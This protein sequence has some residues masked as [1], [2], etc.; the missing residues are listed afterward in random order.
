MV[1]YFEVLYKQMLLPCRTK[2]KTCLIRKKLESLSGVK[3]E[4]IATSGRGTT[5]FLEKQPSLPKELQL[6][7]L[8][9]NPSMKYF[10]C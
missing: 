6:M 7:P 10:I 4:Q 3:L 5:H 2:V 8:S 9:L 1:I